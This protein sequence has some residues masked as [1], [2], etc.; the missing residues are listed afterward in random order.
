MFSSNKTDVTVKINNEIQLLNIPS[1]TNSVN[2]VSDD[3]DFLSELERWSEA[4]NFI[5]PASKETQI[6]CK[7]F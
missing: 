6:A 4:D 2:K 3:V 5:V 1:R 7:L